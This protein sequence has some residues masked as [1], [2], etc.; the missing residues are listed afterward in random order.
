MFEREISIHCE[1]IFKTGDSLWCSFKVLGHIL[2]L[3]TLLC[4]E[5]LVLAACMNWARHKCEQNGKD[6]NDAENLREYFIDDSNGV[7][8]LHKIHYS[9][10]PRDELPI[11]VDELGKLFPDASEREDV[12][13]L[14]LGSKNLKTGKFSTKPRNQCCEYHIKIDLK[15]D[16]RIYCNQDDFYGLND[17]TDFYCSDDSTDFVSH[18]NA[19]DRHAVHFYDEVEFNQ[20]IKINK[21]LTI[22]CFSSS[23]GH[24]LIKGFKFIQL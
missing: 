12:M 18:T 15:L 21:D 1:K 17:G 19:S 24:L 7:N 6:K 22:Q 14:L 8:L 4:D 5:S 9:S 11:H 3:D 10:I 16:Q 20:K 13:L 23:Y 2:D